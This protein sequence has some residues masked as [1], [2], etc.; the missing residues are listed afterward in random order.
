MSLCAVC[1]N[2][3]YLTD[4]EI[5]CADGKFGKNDGGTLTC[6]DINTTNITGVDTNCK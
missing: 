5:C 1:D 4:I 2:S 3:T 6:E